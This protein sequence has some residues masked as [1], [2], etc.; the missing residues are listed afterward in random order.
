MNETT[1]R[2]NDKD[3]SLK[4]DIKALLVLEKLISSH[5]LT[6]MISVFPLSHTDTINCLYVGLLAEHPSMTAQRAMRLLEAWLKENTLVEL[7]NHILIALDRA[8]AIGK[9]NSEE[10]SEETEENLGE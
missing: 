7:Q 8:G 2:I 5:N 3:Y 10:K 1:I 4:Y 6:T 9:T